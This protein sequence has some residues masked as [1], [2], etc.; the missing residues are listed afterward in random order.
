MNI[1]EGLD[2]PLPISLIVSPSLKHLSSKAL[3][4]CEH[5]ERFHNQLASIGL[6]I[7]KHTKIQMLFLDC[8]LHRIIATRSFYSD[9][10]LA[11]NNC[12]TKWSSDNK[13]PYMLVAAQPNEC[14]STNNLSA[15]QVIHH[16]ITT[17]STCKTCNKQD[18]QTNK[19]S[20]TF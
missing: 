7:V 19:D 10:C 11:V 6:A 4:H 8:R 9:L 5:C 12:A 13:S 20:Y 2:G 1:F 17:V 18:K 15:L 14:H 3:E 16:T